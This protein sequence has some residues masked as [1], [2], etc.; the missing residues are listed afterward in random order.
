MKSS[1]RIMV[2]TGVMYARVAITMII[3]LLSSRWILMAL[4]KEDFGIYNLVAGL[5]ALLMFLNLSMSTATQRFLSY[6][7]A[8]E[9]G[10]YLNEV[11][12]LSCV[13]HLCIAIVILVLIE[14]GGQLMIKYLLQIPDGKYD[15]TMFVLHSL[16]ISTF[17]TIISV[18]YNASLLTHENIFFVACVNIIESILKLS[19]AI[20]LLYF[21]GP[22]LKV[23]AIC[24]MGI[25]IMSTIFYRFYCNFKYPETKFIIHKIQNLSLLKEFL[26]YVG[27]NLIGSI[28]SLCRTQG[29]SMLLNSFYGVA[30][31]AAYGIATQVKGQLSFFSSS[32]VSAARPQIVKSEGEGNRDRMLALSNSTC[33]ITFL[34][35]SMIAIPLIIEMEYVLRLWLKDV[36]EY[37]V[38]FT[39]LILILNLVFQFSLGLSIG[40]ESVG[41]IRTLQIIVGGMH[42]IV[43]PIAYIMLKYGMKPYTI[44]IMV[45]L[46]ECLGII[47]KL[48]ISHNITGLNIYKFIKRVL[49]PSI[50]TFGLVFCVCYLFHMIINESFI[51]LIFICFSSI[52]AMIILCSCYTLNEIEKIKIIDMIR[53]LK[54][55]LCKR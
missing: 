1:N 3:T 45:I 21:S 8:K 38:S 29:I 27:W 13:L 25:Q 16:S 46:E 42:F 52:L 35:L 55:K 7:L 39:R 23:Y 49:V 4:G 44:F 10:K 30:I 20:F 40:I 9:K 34:M 12:Y 31:N 43:L 15:V 28:S 26:G 22:R 54:S 53:S 17:F 19:T 36:P 48:V 51:R 37:T 47:I 24:I 50:I 11:F 14:V 18:P 41:N 33:K 6:Y 32:I 2:N 5:L